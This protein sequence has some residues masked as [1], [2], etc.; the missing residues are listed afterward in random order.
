MIQANER[1]VAVVSLSFG[2]GET[3]CSKGIMYQAK[4]SVFVWSSASLTE[5]NHRDIFAKCLFYFAWQIVK[6]LP[7]SI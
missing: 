5:L 7:F 1:L 6:S 4:Y 2:V 3:N